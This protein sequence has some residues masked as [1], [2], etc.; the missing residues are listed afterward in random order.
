MT[1]VFLCQTGELYDF[2]GQRV[3]ITEVRGEPV[4]SVFLYVNF[5]HAWFLLFFTEDTES[6]LF[7]ESAGRSEVRFS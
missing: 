5:V 6:G 7:L 4:P 3:E 2:S 1:D